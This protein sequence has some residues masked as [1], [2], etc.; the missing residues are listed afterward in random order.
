MK[1]T[2]E[3]LLEIG[4]VYI[5]NDSFIL[6]ENNYKFQIT[7]N[8]HYIIIFCDLICFDISGEIIF[9]STVKNIKDIFGAIAEVYYKYGK[10]VQSAHIR[11][12]L[13]LN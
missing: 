3:V 6:E 7:L 9:I 12:L 1:I 5:N 2:K 8:S 4:F 10:Q 13:D 11:N